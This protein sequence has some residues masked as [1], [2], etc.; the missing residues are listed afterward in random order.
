MT[1]SFE[2]LLCTKCGLCCD[3]SLFA[4]V[5]LTERE[6]DRLEAMGFQSI[7]DAEPLIN[8]PCCAQHGKRCGIYQF[9][10]RC[11]RTFECRVLQEA[12]R[13]ILTLAEAKAR[14]DL[15]LR[16][17]RAREAAALQKIVTRYFLAPQRSEEH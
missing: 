2:T 17:K 1:E 6:A 11:C 16:S 14:I 3:G 12:K 8:Q 9:R 5:E 7:D 4:D 15:A 13:G 10:P